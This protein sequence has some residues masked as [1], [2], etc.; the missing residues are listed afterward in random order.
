MKLTIMCGLPD[1]GKST[2]AKEISESTGA[3][4]IEHDSFYSEVIS[5]QP[6]VTQEMLEQVIVN[7]LAEVKRH[8]ENGEN[9]VY[10]SVARTRKRREQFLS[11]CQVPGLETECVY[12]QTP[13]VVCEQRSTDGWPSVFAK[14]FEPPTEDEGFDTLT[15]ITYGEE[16]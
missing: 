4:L 14:S 2:K 8:L 6:I 3:T 9:V 7:A 12:M 5:G 11:T 16:V 13:L 10:D 1:S 15:V